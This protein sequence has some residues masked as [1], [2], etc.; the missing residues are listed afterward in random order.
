MHVKKGDK[1]IV[2]RGKDAGKTGEI[3]RSFPK[4]GKVIV[5]G[6]NKMKRHMKPTK[7]GQ[8]GQTVEKEMPLNVSNVAKVSA[9]K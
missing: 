5:G 1:V 8:K 4:K 7:S 6:I 9:K 2:L 3:V